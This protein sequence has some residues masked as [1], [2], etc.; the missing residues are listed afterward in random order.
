ML[1][2]IVV[3]GGIS[4]LTAAWRLVSAG[5]DIVLLESS[6]RPGGVIQTGNSY[7]FLVERG[8]N[9]LRLND[10][11]E[12]VVSG[13]QARDLLIAGDPRAP[14]YL[15][16]N[17][18]LQRAPMGPL[19]A[20][21]TGLLTKRAKLRLLAEP[22]VR[23][24]THDSDESV[25]S[26]VTRRL[27]REVQEVLVSA[28]L[29]G[30]YAG[31][32]ARMSAAAVFPRLIELEREHGSLLRGAL[33]VIREKRRSPTPRPPRRP[34]TLVSF[35]GGLQRLPEC[36]SVRLGERLR[37]NC[38]VGRVDRERGGYLV[39]SAEGPLRA[40]SLYLATPAGAAAR[41]LAPLD[42]TLAGLLDEI[43]YAALAS[44]TIAYRSEVIGGP[45][46]G[47]GF[48]APRSAG[49]R[50]LGGIFASSLFPD[51]APPGWHSF[52]CFVG[53][54]TD[55]QA[56]S[57]R[58]DALVEI[59]ANDLRRALRADADPKLIELTRW[60]QAIPQYNLGHPARVA[61]IEERAARLGVRL[62]GNYLT[63]VAVGDCAERS[64]R[65]VDSDLRDQKR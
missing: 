61:A 45:V 62:L 32:P 50:V 41:L 60:S 1:D 54:A 33:A 20:V 2:A 29:S 17:G 4:G 31:D 47:F 64:L 35:S 37:L 55:P 16:H 36:I 43:E 44:V 26:F 65:L 11:I 57:L 6:G 12:T 15:Y 5:R 10:A 39:E 49:L 58:D 48:L 30:V 19:S 56:V 23:R 52:T 46:E 34:M 18:R 40:R 59:V 14:R 42:S 8:P 9:S 28:F 51:R 38:P 53:G 25:D 63:G 13:I 27:G 3:G 21:T 24:R 22:F 7:G